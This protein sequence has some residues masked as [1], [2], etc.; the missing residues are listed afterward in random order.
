M[1]TLVIS[2]GGIRGVGILGLLQKIYL[3]ESLNFDNFDV[4]AGSS[5]GGLIS[6]LIC[7]GY[8]PFE[9]FL[10]LS[11]CL[12]LSDFKTRL[13]NI[14]KNDT[15]EDVLKTKNKTLILTSYDLKTNTPLYNSPKTSPNKRI[16]DALV[17]TINVKIFQNETNIDGFMCSP[18]PLSYVKKYTN[19]EPILGLYSYSPVSQTIL[20]FENLLDRVMTIINTSINNQIK[21]EIELSNKIKEGDKI[22][23]YT[24]DE[25]GMLPFTF[26]RISE[27][28]KKGFLYK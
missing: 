4:F 24:G 23:S 14:I 7:Y 26:D 18:F 5:V 21:L 20:P 28:F 6:T 19:G 11:Q 1:K 8:K 22:L 10:E 16:Y 9:V 17:E 25:Q 15:F 2:S 13:E 3:E 27:F 12:L